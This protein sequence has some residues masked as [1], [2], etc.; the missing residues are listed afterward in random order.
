MV[1]DGEGSYQDVIERQPSAADFVEP[2]RNRVGE[3]PRPL[4]V[5]NGVAVKV[6][7]TMPV[8]NA[9]ARASHDQNHE[10]RHYLGADCKT[11]CGW[12]GR[13]GLRRSSLNFHRRLRVHLALSREDLPI[14]L[15]SES[16]IPRRPRM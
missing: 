7:Y 2:G 5:G 4:H 13:D 3:T 16:K 1:I 9:K 14:S 15:T 11:S 12:K 8:E 6:G 10:R